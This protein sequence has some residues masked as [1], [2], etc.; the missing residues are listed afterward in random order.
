MSRMKI[1]PR[2]LALL[3]ALAL[4]ITACGGDG[5]DEPVAKPEIVSFTASTDAVSL[6]GEV[7]LRWQTRNAVEVKIIDGRNLPVDMAGRE[8]EAEGSVMVMPHSTTTYRLIAVGADGSSV[9]S[10][11][12]PVRIIPF[13]GPTIE[14]FTVSPEEVGFGAPAILEWTT[15]NAVSVSIVDNY[16]RVIDL[17]GASA[18]AGSVEVHPKADT[19][20]TLTAVGRGGDKTR[21]D[22]SVSIAQSPSVS[23]KAAKSTITFGET[24]ELVWSA[25]LADHVVVQAE[26]GSPLVD[27]TESK[28][29]TTVVQPSQSTIYVITATGKGGT[30]SSSVPVFVAPQVQSFTQKD[31][32]PVRPGDEVVIE[33]EV[34]GASAIT[35]TNEGGF[36]YEATPAQLVRGSVKARVATTGMFLL[37]A[38]SGNAETR[39][40]LS[41]ELSPAPAI[42]TF[43]ATPDTVFAGETTTLSWFIDGASEITIEVRPDG[44]SEHSKGTYLD[45][46]RL[47]TR[48]DSID[49]VVEEGTTFRLNAKTGVYS[50]QED[51]HVDVR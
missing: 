50:S 44:L 26:G 12:A 43:T 22:A 38:R 10:E 5:E 40:H 24:T 9:F 23:I 33:W 35:I 14:S 51:T 34:I 32:A 1:Y 20:Y 16:G 29:G 21:D 45:T 28:S 39:R 2:P 13:P 15:T 8:K 19:T 47:S 37:I 36:T 25:A 42:R 3:G 11:D 31:A 6:G 18:D 7:E 4:A 27:T 41:L 17:D 46:A 49:V 48:Q 30:K